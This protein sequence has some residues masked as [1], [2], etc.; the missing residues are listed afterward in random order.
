MSQPND[1]YWVGIDRDNPK[2]YP[3]STVSGSDQFTYN[4]GNHQMMFGGDIN[5]YRLTTFEIGQP[6]GGYGFGGNFSAL[7]DPTQVAAGVYGVAAPDTAMGLAD[8]LLGESDGLFLNIYPKYHTRQT[9]FDGYAQDNW[10]VKQNLTVNLG[11]RYTY[12]TAF[13]DAS[14]L[15]STFDPNVPGGMVVYQGTGQPAQ[16]PPAVLASFRAAGLPIESAAQA[17]YP[18]SLFTMPKT[19]FEP[20]L[21]FAYGLNNKTVLRGGWGIYQ[22]VIPLQQFQQASRKN[23]PFSYSSQILP[24]ELSN[25][26][27]TDVSAAALEFPI[28]NASYGGSQ[29]LNQFM[30]GSPAYVLNT[31]N[32][33]ISQGNSFGI[34]PLSP[35]YKPSTVQEWNLSFARQ[36][37]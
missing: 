16:T 8:F 22:W 25:G 35:N 21:G 31:S 11:L 1:N 17:N 29:P 9:E 13:S 26:T 34:A 23:P 12:W 30:L 19:N 33:N 15:Y 32:V 10:R 7:Q 28:A 20:R 2:D 36:L 27:V 37:P 18:S 24:G 4:R 14:G 5:N 6:G 3:D